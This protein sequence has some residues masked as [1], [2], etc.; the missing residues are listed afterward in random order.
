MD[1]VNF[2]FH[3]IHAH[4]NKYAHT[5]DHAHLLIPTTTN[6]TVHMD[7][8]HYNL[9]PYKILFVT[10]NKLHHCYASTDVIIIN[11]PSYMI[12]P[13]DLC[14]LEDC[15]YMSVNKEILSIIKIIKKEILNNYESDSLKYLYYYIYE[16]LVANT[17]FRSIEYIKNH[18]DEDISLVTLANLENYNVNYYTDWFKKQFGCTPTQYI[19]TIRIEKAIKLL[20]CTNLRILDIALQVGYSNNAS[21]TKAF[22]QYTGISPTDYKTN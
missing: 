19:R 1:K 20:N 16:K 4:H 5:H 17:K 12:K 7:G 15:I 18:F 8:I 6:F 14:K 2:H 9:T 3:E 21:F 22:K 11:I 13:D 10:P